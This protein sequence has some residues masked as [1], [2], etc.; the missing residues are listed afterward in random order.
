MNLLPV[1][2]APLANVAAKESTKFAMNGVQVEFH[3]DNTY[4]A[5]ATDSKRIIMVEGRCPDAATFPE[6]PALKSAPNGKS[7]ALVPTDSWSKTFKD[8]AKMTKGRYV[9][10]VLQNV[11]VVCG[12]NEVTFGM[13]NLAQVETPMTRQLEG[14]YPPFREIFPRKSPTVR[15]RVDAKLLADTLKAVAAMGDDDEY[16]TVM[17]EIY[18]PMPAAPEV[19]EESGQLP[20]QEPISVAKPFTLT[21]TNKTN[22]QT[23]SGLCMP[24][25]LKN[26]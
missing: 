10:P 20:M 3:D 1:N 22:G 7:R 8:A 25:S 18:D 9:K 12:E 16:N 13:T 26:H 17:L 24:L 19:D 14:R 11:A 4:T 6:I 23:V 15:L 21:A 5:V 2:L